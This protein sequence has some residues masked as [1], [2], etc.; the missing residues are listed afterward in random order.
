MVLDQPAGRVEEGKPAAPWR[1]DAKKEDLKH[2]GKPIRKV[3][4]RGKVAG[5]TKFADDLT[6]PR[7]LHM[8]LL[9]S[10]VA[11][12]EIVSIDT[13]KAAALPGVKGVLTG[14]DLPI[15]FGILPVSQDE[16]ALC[17]DKVRFVG[18]P[19]VAIAA[20]EEEIAWEA[21]RLVDVQYRELQTIGGI[22]EA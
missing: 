16:H 7:M 22:H 1:H 21:C 6:M 3:D 9:R 4:A 10:T 20:T 2:I 12:A 14:K 17:P 5:L 19:V 8:K 18:D 11:H 13:S 15:P